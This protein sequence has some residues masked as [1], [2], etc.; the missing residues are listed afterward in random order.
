MCEGTLATIIGMMTPNTLASLIADSTQSYYA[1][2][3][4]NHDATEI[5]AAAR[6]ELEGLVGKD[7]AEQ[8][9]AQASN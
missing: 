7:E 2:N 5:A 9:I 8:L 1:R 3:P 6:A 4:A